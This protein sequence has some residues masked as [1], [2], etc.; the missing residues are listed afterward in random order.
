MGRAI[1]AV[2]VG[3]AIVLAV[4]II[5]KLSYVGGDRSFTVNLLLILGMICIVGRIIVAVIM[6][7]ALIAMYLFLKDKQ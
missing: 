7:V 2:I 3:A 6:I 4:I 5:A 1:V